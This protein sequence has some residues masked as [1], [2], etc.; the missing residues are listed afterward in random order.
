MSFTGNEVGVERN[1]TQ[2]LFPVVPDVVNR[3]AD[4][5]V[6]PVISTALNGEVVAIYPHRASS[7]HVLILHLPMME[8]SDVQVLAGLMDSAEPVTVRY[9]PGGTDLVCV[10]GPRSSQKFIPLLGDHPEAAKDGSP[11]ASTLLRY[12]VT[13]TFYLL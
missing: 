5:A 1:T 3:F 6:D 12:E 4:G 10:F 7:Q 11:I 9:A 13:L 2:V 8:W